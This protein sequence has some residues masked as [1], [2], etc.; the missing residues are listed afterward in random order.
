MRRPIAP[1]APTELSSQHAP[2][3]LARLRRG[4]AA[5]AAGRGG[6]S[7]D[8]GVTGKHA[9][10]TTH[11]PT[12]TRPKPPAGCRPPGPICCLSPSALQP[13][14]GRA[15]QSA[16]PTPLRC[17]H[18]TPR[19][20]ARPHGPPAQAAADPQ[21]PQGRR[22]PLRTALTYACAGAR[23]P[24][25]TKTPACTPFQPATLPPRH[26]LNAGARSRAGAA[27]AADTAGRARQGRGLGALCYS[28]NARAAQREA[29][30]G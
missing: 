27:R 20:R 23:A 10:V 4:G 16:S 21:L 11:L 12:H 18:L 13:P 3:L 6:H 22:K 8:A 15:Y 9:R 14:A 7:P 26:Q 30:A 28:S 19:R 2:W 5:L 29:D 1:A 24:R 25:H 17:A